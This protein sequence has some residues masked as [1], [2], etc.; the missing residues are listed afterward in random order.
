[1]NSASAPVVWLLLDDRAGNRAQCLGVAAALGPAWQEREIRYGALGRLPNQLLGAS[2][3]GL[4]GESR[5]E[6]VPPWPDLVIAAG[7]R[8][9]PVARRIKRLSGGRA[10]IAQIMDP[11]AGADEFDLI[12]V[13]RHDRQR[14]ATNQIAITGAPHRLNPNVLAEAAEQW[15]ERFA[16]L[17]TPRIGLIVGGSTRRR[18]FTDA[19]GRELG[20]RANRLAESAGGSLLITTSRR[21]GEAAASL[22]ERITVPNYRFGWGDTGENPYLGYLA[23]ADGVIV[24]GDSV[25]MATEACATGRP[26][27]LYAPKDLITAKHARLHR[28]LVNLGHARP[29]GELFDATWR[30]P[31]LNPAEAVAAEIHRRMGT[32]A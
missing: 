29:L 11:G 26:V 18:A 1:M 21:T 3:L 16:H 28:E 7:R 24:T 14:V 5:A 32:V 9:A 19:M 25:S 31:P 2:F 30:H 8:T 4:S 27:Y 13:P 20:E 17:P 10:F 12:A 23:L 15:R 6:L 22:L